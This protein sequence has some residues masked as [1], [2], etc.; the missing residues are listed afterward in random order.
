MHKIP[1][2]YIKYNPP[3][4]KSK[5]NPVWRPLYRCLGGSLKGKKGV[6]DVQDTER[7]YNRETAR[8]DLSQIRLWVGPASR[9][10][11]AKVLQRDGVYTYCEL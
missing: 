7:R 5:I 3:P 10:T 6:E 11:Y 8:L 1:L 9:C 4:R 2:R